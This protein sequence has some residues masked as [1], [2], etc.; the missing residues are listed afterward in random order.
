MSTDHRNTSEEWGAERGTHIR[1]KV[2]CE[3]CSR[4]TGEECEAS[5]HERHIRPYCVREMFFALEEQEEEKS[6]D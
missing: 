4:E 3:V 6:G 1:N 2:H 5:H